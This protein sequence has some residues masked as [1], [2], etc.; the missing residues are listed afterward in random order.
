MEEKRVVE[1]WDWWLD[2]ETQM[3]YCLGSVDGTLYFCESIIQELPKDEEEDA[4]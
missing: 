1:V 2:R 3:A 4:R